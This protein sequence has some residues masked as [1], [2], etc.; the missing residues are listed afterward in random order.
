M[1]T[2]KISL[3]DNL[4]SFVDEQ[5]SHRG[6]GSSSEYVCDLLRKDQGRQQLNKLLLAGESSKPTQPITTGY[7]DGLRDKVRKNTK[8]HSLR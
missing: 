7:F 2:I 5:V 1:N 6:Y 3:S 4:K 8:L